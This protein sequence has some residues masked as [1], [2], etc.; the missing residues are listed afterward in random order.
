MINLVYIGNKL[1][2][3]KATVTSIDVLGPLLEDEGFHIN[4]ASSIS[5]KG[6]RFF[7]MVFTVVKHRKSTDYVLIDTY[8]TLNFYYAYVISQLCR[9]LKLKC[10]PVLHGGNLPD[11]LIKNPKMCQSIFNHAFKNV[12]PS[13]YLKSRFEN[14][15]YSNILNI[16]NSI[17]IEAYRFQQRTIDT[18][19]LLWV[20]AFDK[21]YN[22]LL[23]ID[24]LKAL[25]DRGE[26]ATLTMVGPD[27][28][29]T[30]Q[31]AIDYADKLGVTVNFTGKLEKEEWIKLS[32]QCNVF[33]N[34]TNFDN[35][36]VSVIEAM[37]LGLPVVSTNVGGMP[38]L[39]E[40][41]QD[42]ILVLPNSVKAFVEAIMSLKNDSNFTKKITLNARKKVEQY[43]W[44]VVKSLWLSL[45]V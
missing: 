21:I 31:Q 29:G 14:E 7:D 8:S 44:E 30:L 18:I 23:A 16:P 17:N 5:N 22:P 36:P 4:Y 13:Q 33:M 24:V 11:R 2:N 40:D 27:K 25:Q 35:M 38:F 15:G 26:P 20:R 28:D 9:V 34:T 41:E 1:N 45:L 42:G 19:H 6:L 32:Q 12:A 10:I 43:D 39:I 3:T 37:A